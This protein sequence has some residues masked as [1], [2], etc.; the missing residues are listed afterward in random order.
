MNYNNNSFIPPT[1]VVKNIYTSAKTK[2]FLIK[3][4]SDKNIAISL[5]Y[6]IWATTPKNEYKFVSA[7]MEHD[8][9]IL[10]FSVNGSSKFCGYAIMQ[11]KPGESKNNNVY[12]YYDN[13]VFRGKNFDIQ[14]IRVIDVP[15]QEVAHLK[16]S[17]NENKPIKVGRD[18]QE[19]EQMAGI[20][21]C[22]AFESNF[23]KI[24]NNLTDTNAK[25]NI[26]PMY[27]MNA[28]N[29]VESP[30]MNEN[31]D[32]IKLYPY[33]NNFNINYNNFRNLYEE[34][35]Y[36]LFNF[37]NP[38]LHIFPIDLTNMNYDEYIYLYEKS[39]LVWQ[40]KMLQMKANMNCIK[41]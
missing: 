6:N 16:N 8:Y 9:V 26:P 18:G 12:F 4:S 25:P 13:K 32:M 41:Q 30:N 21:L 7:F 2:F 5:N 29:Y 35:Q 1:H 39:Q 15:F 20:Q 22:E 19:I 23:I 37:Y 24:N 14:W 27:N 10:V 38:A 31:I 40:Q 28:N 33:N 17:L 11:S 3:S 36:N 34:S